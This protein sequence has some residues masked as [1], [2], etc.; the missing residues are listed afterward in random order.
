M[1]GTMVRF[2]VERGEKMRHR[3]RLDALRRV[4]HEHRAL[5]R[6]QGA[7]H[8][9]AEVHVAGR[10]DQV[11]LVLLAP[12]A[13]DHAHGAGLDRDALLPFQIHG[14][15]ELLAHFPLGDGVGDLH[16]AVGQRALAV[17]DVGDD[18]KVANMV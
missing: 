16:Q 5:A 1:T 6:L 17:V 11:D 3:L 7:V 12:V 15:E 10:V 14:V 8:L 9:V 2:C 13:V 4:H 18:R